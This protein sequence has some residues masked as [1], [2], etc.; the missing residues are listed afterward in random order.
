MRVLDQTLANK[1]ETHA[2]AVVSGECQG[3]DT[4]GRAYAIERGYRIELMEYDP[5]LGRNASTMRHQRMVEAADAI[6]AFWDGKSEGT[7]KLLK[8]MHNAGKSIRIVEVD[9]IYQCVNRF[10]AYNLEEEYA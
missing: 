5:S 7:A 3:P 2:I 8:M 6:V 4:L 1:K 9:C 10:V